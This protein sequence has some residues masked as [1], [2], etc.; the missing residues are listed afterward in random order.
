MA[1]FVGG[2]EVAAERLALG[3]QGAGHEVLVALGR[4]GEVLERMRG[5]G[6]RC[7]VTPM[8]FTDKWRP[9]RFAL[10]RA[11][12][13][14]LLRRER[15]GVVHG[16]DLPTHQVLSGAARGLGIPV[17]CH[18]RFPFQ[19]PAIDW[20]NKY[21]ADRHLFVSRA[22][23]DQMCGESAR[24]AAS[25]RSVV[26]DGLPL[27]P[28]PTEEDRAAARRRLGLPA[29]KVLVLFAGQVIERKGVEDLIR[30]WAALGPDVAARAELLIVGDDLQGGGAYRVAM[31]GLAGRLGCPARFVGFRRDVADWLVAAD[32]AAV[33][34]HVEPLG[35]ATLEAMA[36]GRP[37]VGGRVG[38][39]PEMVVPGETG[40]LVPPRSPGDLAAALRRL[41]GDA[42]LRARLGERGR[43]RCEERFGLQGHVRAVVR[44]YGQVLERE[45]RR[46]PGW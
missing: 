9:W 16:N 36:Q 42:A 1:P 24:L 5:A 17:V 45:A 43:A 11:R 4:R 41:I 19:G 20:F 38:G 10:A 44:E 30:A 25:D 40:L 31:Q 32:V 12:L 18:H 23:M 3:L 22:L 29:G 26:Y 37:V 35:N 2:A 6:L 27:P 15:P 33:P 46:V 28:R 13:R 39:I 14:R 8:C 34:S 7:L 21:G